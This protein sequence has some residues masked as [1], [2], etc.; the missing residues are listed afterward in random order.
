M[1]RGPDNAHGLEYLD[2][3][4]E[5]GP[6]QGREYPLEVVRSPAGEARE[7]LRFPYD[8]LALDNRL[9]SLEIALLR[10]GGQRRRLLSPEEQTVQD[11][12]R[13]LFD[14][15][16]TGD[17]RSRYDLSRREAAAGGKGLRLKLRVTPPELAALPWEFL[18]DARQGEFVALSLNTPI[19]RYPIVSSPI[20]PLRVTPP[21]RVLAMIANPRNLQPLDVERERQR[22]EASVGRLREHGLIELRW[23]EGET[24]RDLQR[25]MRSGPWHIFHFVGHGGFDREADEGLIALSGDDGRAQYLTATSLGRLLADHSPLRLVLLNACEGARGSQRDIFSST[26]SILVRRG[27]PAVLA[28]QY[29][30]TDDAAIEFS[31][32]FYEAVA[33]GLPLDAAVS[34]A[35]KAISLAIA[36][37]FEWGTPV[38]FLR[39]P[40]GR[41]FD[42]DRGGESRSETRVSRRETAAADDE[43]QRRRLEATYTQALSAF[44][45]ASWPRAIT[46]L[47][48]IVA[49]RADYEDAADK[50]REA[51]RQRDLADR[52]AAGI[53]ACE[54][55]AW[56]AA[57][58]HLRAV[59]ELDPDYRDAAARLRD[60]EQQARLAELYGE[61]RRLYAAGAWPAVITVFSR[62]HA[63]DPA[64]EDPKQLLTRARESQAAA[65]RAGDLEARYRESL[66][67]MRDGNWTAAVSQLEAIERIEPGYRESRALLERARREI[68]ARE[69]PAAPAPVSEAAAPVQTFQTASAAPS[70]VAEPGVAAPLARESRSAALA[71]PAAIS[72]VL[73]TLGWMLAWAL[74]IALY[75][76]SEEDAAA[77]VLGGPFFYGFAGWFTGLAISV[78]R[79]DESRQLRLWLGAAWALAWAVSYPIALTWEQGLQ[80]PTWIISILL[81]AG[82]ALA[83]WR[84]LPLA[85]W[86]IAAFGAGLLFAQWSGDPV[87]SYFID[88]WSG[89]T[90]SWIPAVMSGILIAGAYNG[91]FNGALIV[92][93]LRGDQPAS[94]PNAAR[95]LRQRE[96]APALAA[97]GFMIGGFAGLAV[98]ILYWDRWGDIGSGWWH[99]GWALGGLITGL[100]LQS[101]ARLR[102]WRSIA[103]IAA[104]W[105]AALWLMAGIWEP[106]Y[107]YKHDP[108]WISGWL[109][110]MALAGAI[111]GVITGIAV[112]HAGGRAWRLM[113]IA[114]GWA[115][116]LAAAGLI[117]GLYAFQGYE[118]WSAGNPFWISG[119]L[120]AGLVA[121][122]IGGVITLRAARSPRADA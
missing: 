72:V 89:N 96:V 107:D 58:D 40:D 102:R 61:A 12:G 69:Q 6:G 63:L 113:L 4:I 2:F 43:S 44:Y 36:N 90:M 103:L 3:E 28:M 88:R 93:L 8:S 19:V 16:L 112:S 98:A 77:L 84:L 100:V 83:L 9:Q 121:G 23:L 80:G 17:V 57:V 71:G 22:I 20:Q 87:G 99:V 85:R 15:L 21:L 97:G 66:A 119:W 73:A 41:I 78:A 56:P 11:F 92:A 105:A 76:S 34:E 106:I 18:Y 31:R 108:P 79:G 81:S 14:A 64:Y 75:I 42:V 33:D 109:A 50:L 117:V 27:I 1:Q 32:T 13:A 24:W 86:R 53:A 46:L 25:A 60:A 39:S 114:A 48:G 101:S 70:L 104:G 54:S 30:I 37:T 62:I 110:G 55:R 120:L 5:I 7:T 116:A 51:R 115:L 49:E 29:E 91:I 26:A 45:T 67:S 10:S 68:A 74:L 82:T 95:V 47:E 65:D 52:Y 118:W 59:I 35:R 111:G 38:L 94:A 122:V